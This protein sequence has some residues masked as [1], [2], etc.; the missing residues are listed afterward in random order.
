MTR[1]TAKVGC[2]SDGQVTDDEVTR[3]FARKKIGLT[4][5]KLRHR[6]PRSS[7]GH[8]SMAPKKVNSDGVK[9]R[10]QKADAKLIAHNKAINKHWK[11]VSYWTDV[12]EDYEENDDE[13]Q[14]PQYRHFPTRLL[15]RILWAP[16]FLSSIRVILISTS[17]GLCLADTK[18]LIFC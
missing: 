15:Q 13:N 3:Y 14:G 18:L 8:P 2:S 1:S 17:F 6:G 4:N 7:K 5:A 11:G 10:M 12:E 16:Y 9:L